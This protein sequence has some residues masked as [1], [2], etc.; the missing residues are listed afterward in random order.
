M[1]YS[2]IV[3]VVFA[4]GCRI[5]ARAQDLADMTLRLRNFLLKMFL[6]EVFSLVIWPGRIHSPRGE[7]R[8]IV[9]VGGVTDWC[10]VP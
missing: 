9:S 7:V 1:L 5:F 4:I 6:V 2:L 8:S 10:V 3:V